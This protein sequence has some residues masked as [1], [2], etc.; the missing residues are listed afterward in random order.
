MSALRYL[1]QAHSCDEYAASSRFLHTQRWLKRDAYPTTNEQSTRTLTDLYSSQPTDIFM[2][3]KVSKKNFHCSPIGTFNGIDTLQDSKYELVLER[4]L[5]V[6]FGKEYDV[7]IEHL[8]YAQTI[9]SP[10]L[11]PKGL[12][13]RDGLVLEGN[14]FD[15]RVRVPPF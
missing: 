7:A 14:I 1:V 12:L 5:D 13:S 11:E 2:V 15:R 6:R 8:S 9:E 10:D 3:G 4:P